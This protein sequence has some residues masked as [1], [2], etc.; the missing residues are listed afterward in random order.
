MRPFQ[1]TSMIQNY[2]TCTSRPRTPARTL[3]TIFS[4]PETMCAST[5]RGLFKLWTNESKINSHPIR[6]STSM[7]SNLFSKNT[8]VKNIITP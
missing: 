8:T 3:H 1:F 2:S 6:V 4:D 7:S 5:S